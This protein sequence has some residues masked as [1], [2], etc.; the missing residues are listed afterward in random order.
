[1]KRPAGRR[2]NG[3]PSRAIIAQHD[4]VARCVYACPHDAAQRMKGSELLQIVGAQTLV[5]ERK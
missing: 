3:L 4:G 1:M 5:G 2:R